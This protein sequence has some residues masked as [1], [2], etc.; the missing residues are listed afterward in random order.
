MGIHVSIKQSFYT[1]FAVTFIYLHN[2][3]VRRFV[4]DKYYMADIE[5]IPSLFLT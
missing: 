3:I 4:L 2:N 5:R 1:I